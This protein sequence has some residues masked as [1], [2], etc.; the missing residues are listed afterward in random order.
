M[1]TGWRRIREIEA[2]RAGVRAM[3]AATPHGR[4]SALCTAL[5]ALVLALAAS[6]APAAGRLADGQWESAITT[7]GVTRTISYCIRPDEAASI[8]GDSR[9]ARAFADKKAQK[10]GAPCSFK[11]YEV[12]GDKV[13]YTMLCGTRTI[14]DQ[15]VYH[16]QTSDGVKTITKEGQTVSMQISSRRIG[17]CP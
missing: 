15:T 1:R 16:G 11:S 9:T 6:A 5:A 2:H 13:S 7:D 3:I 4:P 12:S 17:T 10:A 14:T 8:N